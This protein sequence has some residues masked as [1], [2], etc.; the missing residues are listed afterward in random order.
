VVM[1]REDLLVERVFGVP[2]KHYVFAID[3]AS[4]TP[5]A[6]AGR[7]I[8]TY[9][10]DADAKRAGERIAR[11]EIQLGFDAPEFIAGL[12]RMRQQRTGARLTLA[13][14]LETFKDMSFDVLQKYTQQMAGG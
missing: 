2:A 6:L 5:M 8:I 14:D 3:R 4:R 12:K 9:G 7:L 1:V 10:S 13:F 11:G